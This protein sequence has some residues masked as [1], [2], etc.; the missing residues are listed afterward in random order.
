MILRNSGNGAPTI[1]CTI[2][3][4]NVHN[5]I[6][7][8]CLALKSVEELVVLDYKNAPAGYI[9]IEDKKIE[10][11]F[12]LADYFGYGFGKRLI[13]IAIRDYGC[14]YVDVNEQNP[15]P[16]TFTGIWASVN[17]NGPSLMHRDILSL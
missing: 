11:L 5:L 6:P 17:M 15:R 4:S 1:S 13:D 2:T 14:I 8:V 12:I 16:E 3:E 10:I 9:G 7:D